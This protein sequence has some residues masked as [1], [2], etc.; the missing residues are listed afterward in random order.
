M[1]LCKV[2]PPC[3]GMNSPASYK[4]PAEAGSQPSS[5]GFALVAG[6]FIVTLTHGVRS[7]NPL[8]NFQA[9]YLAYF[10][11]AAASGLV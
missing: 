4:K 9:L 6:R 7:L 3:V 8:H 10:R 2:K 11:H 1:C 5:L